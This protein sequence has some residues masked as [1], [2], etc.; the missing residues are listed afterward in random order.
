MSDDRYVPRNYAADCRSFGNPSRRI[1]W[2]TVGDGDGEIPVSEQDWL[3]AAKI[4]DQFARRIRSS[5]TGSVKEYAE[6]H[7]LN[8]RRLGRMLRGEVVMRLEDIATAERLLQMPRAW[9][10]TLQSELA[11]L[12][13]QTEDRANH[14]GVS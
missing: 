8:E 1:E 14:G 6:T 3:R 2:R 5:I 11:E 4:Q 13:R 9:A 10:L 12:R 7:G